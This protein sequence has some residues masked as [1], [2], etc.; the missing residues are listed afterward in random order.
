MPSR[1]IGRMTP[2]ITRRKFGLAL[3]LIGA[4]AVL[5]A[6][7]TP[8]RVTSA[9][10]QARV[11]QELQRATGLTLSGQTHMS[12]LALPR[13]RLLLRNV[14][15]AGPGDVVQVEAGAVE[16]VFA[17]L[18][19]IGSRFEF[20]AV[21]LD[22]ARI[23]VNLAQAAAPAASATQPG[24]DNAA[25]AAATP[26]PWRPW[27]L[28][29]RDSTVSLRLAG[30]D[31]EMSATGI[32]MD[33]DWAAPDAPASF[34]GHAVISQ[35][36]ADISGFVA[37]PGAL[38]RG[39]ATPASLKLSSPAFAL[40]LDGALN[41][42]SGLRFAGALHGASL[43][44]AAL[45]PAVEAPETRASLNGLVDNV[46]RIDA[47]IDASRAGLQLA[48]LRVTLGGA[49]L[50][51]SLQA[52]IPDIGTPA[53]RLSLAG[54]LA[55]GDLNLTPLAL[56]LP[57]WQ[58]WLGQWNG[59]PLDLRWL[60]KIDVDARL[61]AGRAAVGAFKGEDIA[62]SL[63]LRGG[64]Y[65]IGLQ[66]MRAYG[67]RARASL[68]GALSVTEI[69]AKGEAL[70]SGVDMARLAADAPGLARLSGTA[71]GAAALTARGASA[72]DLV[73]SLAGTAELHL[74]N[75]EIQGLNFEQALRRLD[76]KPASVPATLTAGRTVFDTL[77]ATA[78]IANGVARIAEGEMTGPGV[79]AVFKGDIDL[80]RK[81][82]AL[83]SVATPAGSA[84]SEGYGQQKLSVDISGSLSDP[85][86]IPRLSG[87]GDP[88]AGP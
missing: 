5:I 19:L 65:D 78:R 55:G 73:G 88:L 53:A 59:A 4:A 34:A 46:A 3:T 43:S 29:L 77:T 38:Q 50:E 27:R 31:S 39:G 68:A 64:R 81:R 80:E 85:V 10:L 70:F 63:L 40:A 54:T 86:L 22:D 42:A 9:R 84:A 56:L 41:A 2:R 51:G 17:L 33:F 82:I 35:T 32:D 60:R 69:E 8:W 11:A 25:D 18:P 15:L 1:K 72:A 48:A 23:R 28:A 44:L 76:R 12:L 61:S 74:A 7:L 30:D 87:L 21:R 58:D 16:S 26:P 47:Q 14:T 83:F 66:E 62:L 24:Q 37:N 49:S 20:A 57:Q 6:G 75:G 52:G 13:P 45:L 71:Q 67:G 79:R 36:L